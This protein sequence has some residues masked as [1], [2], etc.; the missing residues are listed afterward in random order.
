MATRI[1]LVVAAIV[2]LLV[3]PPAKVGTAPTRTPV[4]LALIV[5]VL[6]IPPVTAE[7]LKILMPNP[8]PVVAVMVPLLTI[9]P[10]MVLLLTAMPVGK[11]AVVVIVPVFVLV[12][13]PVT[14][15]PTILMQS[16]A[17][18]LVIAPGAGRAG[19]VSGD[20]ARRRMGG[21][22]AGHAQHG[23]GRDQ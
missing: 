3:M 21:A 17:A 11:L 13:L 14:V 18:A 10:L 12:T 4:R 7:P 6:P 2:P 16:M 22:C 5:P 15:E 23:A 20:G 19:V 9:A 1:P 8:A